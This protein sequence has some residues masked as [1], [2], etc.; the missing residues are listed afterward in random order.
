M[1][2]RKVR[3]EDLTSTIMK[4]IEALFNEGF[5]KEIIKRKFS[6]GNFR[7][8]WEI[9]INFPW[10]ALWL[11]TEESDED[12]EE[13]C[14]GIIGGATF[15]N[16]ITNDKMAFEVCWR[17]AKSIKGQGHGWELF[18]VFLEWAI[19]EQGANRIMTHRFISRDLEADERFDT[20]I[21]SLG[22]APSGCEYY[23]DV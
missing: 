23:M 19:K 3:L 22:F 14:F 17:T 7:D 12:G 11:L 1:E 21:R 16:M 5:E 10:N 13:H 15:P 2:I 20:K 18:M 4:D 9:A 6:W 8:F